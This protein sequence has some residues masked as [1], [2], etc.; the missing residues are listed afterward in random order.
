MGPNE[1]IILVCS[2]LLFAY[3][4]DISA[5]KTRI[6][7]VILLLLTGFAAK[8]LLGLLGIQTPDFSP[9]LPVFG[10]LGLIL[11]VL[12]GAMELHIDSTRL[13]LIKKTLFAAVLPLFAI[14]F[15]LALAISTYS[16]VPFRAA[17]LN[18]IPVAIISSAIAIPSARHLPADQREF[19]IYESSI[20]DIIGVLLFNFIHQNES[21]TFS[22][23]GVFGLQLLA[24]LI[25]TFAATL[26]LAFLIKRIRHH[27]KFAPIIILLIMVYALAK[28]LHLPAL[29]FVLIFGLFLAN[30]ER[31]KEWKI[32]RRLN[33][34]SFNREIEKFAEITAEGTFLIRAIFFLIFGFLI[35]PE[36]VT[37]PNSLLFA[38][39][40]FLLLVGYRFLTLSVMRQP[41]HP[42]LFL[43]PRG[44]ITVLLF[45]SIEPEL[46]TEIINKSFITQ[47]ILLTALFLMP[48]NLTSKKAIS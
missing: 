11:I 16:E 9:L 15:T 10:T 33:P 47:V 12:E 35:A 44:L 38:A 29:L 14:S 32:F 43:A 8:S 26:F 27:V 2:L 36:E 21:V 5:R 42:L 4:F 48:G 46:Q 40:T 30:A 17:L 22:S 34:G 45:L 41:L 20:S 37:N 28:M 24:M 18:A 25:I 3:L 7:S 31:L 23:V 1:I 13:P 6:P 39:L 19:V